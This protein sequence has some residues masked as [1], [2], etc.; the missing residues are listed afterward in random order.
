MPELVEFC[1]LHELKLLTIADLG[2][3]RFRME[4]PRLVRTPPTRMPLTA[5]TFS[6]VGY[7][8]LASGGEHLAL[9]HGDRGE[10]E[11]VLVGIS[12]ECLAATS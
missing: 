10:G 9:V 11:D 5:G 7:G 8:G 3:H 12:R 1:R 6:A 4:R 2:N